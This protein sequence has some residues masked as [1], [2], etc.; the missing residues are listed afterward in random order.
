MTSCEIWGIEGRSS[1]EK[2][3]PNR[4]SSL[5]DLPFLFKAFVGKREYGHR[6]GRELGREKARENALG[7]CRATRKKWALMTKKLSGWPAR[8]WIGQETS[9][10]ENW[11]VLE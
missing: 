7:F 5:A 6:D 10:V 11:G 4:F 3:D 1:Q 8:E 9:R 2:D